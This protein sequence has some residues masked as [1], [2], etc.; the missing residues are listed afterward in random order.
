VTELKNA[1][2]ENIEKHVLSFGERLYVERKRQNLSIEDVAK[3]I[4]LS[5][6]VIDAIERSDVIHLPQPTFVQGYLRAY[7]KHLGMSETLVLEEYANAVPHKQESDLHPRSTLPDEASSN[8]FFIKMITIMIL[9]TMVV[10]AIYALS[11]YYKNAIVSNEDEQESQALLSLPE[12]DTGEQIEFEY[13]ISP[14]SYEQ[15]EMV[16][17][18]AIQESLIKNDVDSEE[19]KVAET[20]TIEPEQKTIVQEDLED[21]KVIAQVSADGDDLLK[22]SAEQVSWVEVK[23][24]KGVNLYYNLLQVGQSVSLQ[25]TAPFKVFLGNAPVVKIIINDIAVNIDNHIRSNNIASF[26]IS[27]DQQQIVFH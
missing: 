9:G 8:T 11:S 23:D 18:D 27:V 10:A 15:A 24:A 17:S 4:H 25:G 19:E 21:Q 12:S 3:A 6:K 22:L 1:E 2:Q 13:E 5:E 16:K 26:R 20:I 14:E 7:A